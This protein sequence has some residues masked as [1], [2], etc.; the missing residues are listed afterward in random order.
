[1]RK[2][3]ATIL[4][5]MMIIAAIPLTMVH[6]ATVTAPTTLS[7]GTEIVLT[8][9]TDGTMT[10][11]GDNVAVSK[12]A[13]DFDG[14]NKTIFDGNN[15]I[16]TTQCKGMLMRVDT[17]EGYSNPQWYIIITYKDKKT[18]Y[19]V[20]KQPYK[21]WNGSSWSDGTPKSNN[22][23]NSKI[24]YFYVDFSNIGLT[25]TEISDL[26]LVSAK[27]DGTR[28]GT[29]SEWC[30]VQTKK[31]AEQYPLVPQ[32][33]E[34]ET[35]PAPTTFP[36]TTT[37]MLYKQ[38]TD[39]YLTQAG[40]ANVFRNTKLMSEAENGKTYSIFDNGTVNLANY[41]GIMTKVKQTG[42]GP[43]AM[44]WYVKFQGQTGNQYI[45]ALGRTLKI[46]N[47]TEW[48]DC[49]SK[50]NAN[51]WTLPNLG[52][53]GEAYVYL[54]FDQV[55]DKEF[56][57]YGSVATDL[58]VHSTKVEGRTGVFSE[59]ALVYT[60]DQIITSASV[61]L[62]D[63]LA[64]NVKANAPDGCT[65]G[66]M[67]F[68][69]NGNNTQPT[70]TNGRYSLT[71]IL[72]Q[73]IGMDITATWTGTVNGVTITD[74]VTSSI[75]SYCKTILA[76]EG[77]ADWHELAKALLH[78]GAAAQAATGVEGT[79]CNDG[80]DAVT[81]PVDLT[82]IN[83]VITNNDTAV[84]KGATLR[85]DGALALKIRLDAPAGVTKVTATVDGRDSVELDIVDGYVVLPLNAYELF[86]TVTFSYG[87]ADKTLVMSADYVLKNTTNSA[88]VALA[89]AVANYGSEA[90]QK[91]A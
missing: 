87:D 6:A 15:I 62:T 20:K 40:T 70:L 1:M 28:A 8:P 86:K 50:A 26:K 60:A 30:F 55:K 21:W 27:S 42:T 73:Q 36:N 4:A 17:A 88:Y 18:T 33:P 16:D 72:P 74:S 54:S 11:K 41:S 35:I 51:N 90:L 63:D 32:E 10:N 19:N 56:V 66:T 5:L 48:K 80:V 13:S 2:I 14:T 12:S 58:T 37:T 7:D 3:L 53:G 46:W 69:F 91:K 38:I 29:F 24:G 34:P 85:L 44:R 45:S 68:S 78:Y 79:P 61:S 67:T 76:T 49:T 75:E 57:D 84:W 43:L 64:W 9:I 83:P 52:E 81:N 39:G 59:W 47:G 77:Q 23:G 31:Q 89:K 25:Q 65:D 22:D 82:A 71:G